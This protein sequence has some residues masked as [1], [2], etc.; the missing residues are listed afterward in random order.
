VGSFYKFLEKYHM[1]K[2]FRKENLIVMVL[3]GILLAVIAIP[4]KDV[5]G[6]ESQQ[7]MQNGWEIHANESEGVQEPE[8]VQKPEENAMDYVSNLESKLALL[9]SKIEGAGEVYV[10]IS[11]QESE[12]FVVEKDITEDAENTVYASDGSTSAPYVIKTIYPKVEGVAVVAEGAGIG[13]VTQHITEV[14]QTLFDLEPH[15]VKVT[16]S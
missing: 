2:W 10:M 6:K 13:R 5:G 11:L 16:G 15:K 9:L 3:V 4:T 14:V 1:E 8:E 7:R 12:E